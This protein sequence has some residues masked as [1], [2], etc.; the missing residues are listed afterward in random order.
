MNFNMNT[1][2]LHECQ[3]IVEKNYFRT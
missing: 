2:I 1:S 3:N